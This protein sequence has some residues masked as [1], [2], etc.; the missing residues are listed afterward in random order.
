MKRQANKRLKLLAVL[1]LIILL[2]ILVFGLRGKGFH[3]ANDATWL[4]DESGVRF[5]NFSIAYALLD[6]QPIKS[7]LSGIEAFSIEVALKSGEGN[8]PDGFKLIL[9]L[10]DGDDRRQLMV[11]QYRSYLVVMNG[12]DY[13]NKRKIR[14]I[15]ANIFPPTSGRL[16]LTITSGADGTKLYVDGKLFKARSDLILKVPHE[17]RLRMTLGNSVYGS[18]PWKGEVYALAFYGDQL[19]AEAVKKRYT[20]WSNTRNFPFPNEGKPLLFFPFDEKTGSVAID[21]LSGTEKVNL[22]P[23]FPILEKQFLSVPGRNFKAN[24]NFWM[25]F[26]LNLLGF[27][28]LGAVL[29]ALFHEAGGLIRK[30]AVFFSSGLSFLISL[31]IE[32]AQVWMPSRS[33]QMTDLVLNTLGALLGA[34]ICQSLLKMKKQN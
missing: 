15:A 23:T 26:I 34:V 3:F 28:P 1:S 30:Q 12:D 11:G 29:W 31:G 33:S 21:H 8:K 7:K 22:P 20:V 18:S 4:K 14:R 17:S 6:Q 32:T 19:A 27:I 16:F 13:E 25:D 24:S 9:T 10:Q 5:G 2:V